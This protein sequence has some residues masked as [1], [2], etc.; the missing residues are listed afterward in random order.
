MMSPDG[1]SV[2]SHEGGA[3]ETPRAPDRKRRKMNSSPTPGMPGVRRALCINDVEDGKMTDDV[4]ESKGMKVYGDS[5]APRRE[6]TLYHEAHEEARRAVAAFRSF[7]CAQYNT[8][9]KHCGQSNQGRCIVKSI[10]AHPNTG[11]FNWVHR[12]CAE[13][14]EA[15]I[16]SHRKTVRSNTQRQNHQTIF[17]S[18]LLSLLANVGVIQRT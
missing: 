8:G 13:I 2:E 9:C 16:L 18:F 11:N 6:L 15:R 7:S 12:E 1:W 3:A 5:L 4:V 10:R 17:H 14:Y